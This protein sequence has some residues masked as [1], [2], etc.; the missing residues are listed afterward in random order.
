MK[1]LVVFPLFIFLFLSIFS[2]SAHAVIVMNVTSLGDTFVDMAHP[3]YGDGTNQ[4]LTV[5]PSSTQNIFSYFLYN[6]SQIPSNVTISS[7]Q[8]CV[9]KL[10]GTINGRQILAYNTSPMNT[11][12]TTYWNEGNLKLTNCTGAGC[13]LDRN[14]TWSTHPAN[15]TLL[16]NIT[17][18]TT[19]GWKC[20]NVTKAMISS[21][22]QSKPLSIM[23]MDGHTNETTGNNNNFYSKEG[24]TPPYLTVTFTGSNGCGTTIIGSY[25]DLSDPSHRGL[26]TTPDY[27]CTHDL[28]TVCPSNS[29]C[30]QITPQINITTAP[31]QNGVDCTA[32]LFVYAGSLLLPTINCGVS[33][34]F[35]PGCFWTNCPNDPECQC[36]P[37]NIIPACYAN[38]SLIQETISSTPASLGVYQA[39][40]YDPNTKTYIIAVDENGTNTTIT[41]ITLRFFPNATSYN[42]TNETAGACYA[43]TSTVCYNAVCSPVACTAAG[44]TTITSVSWFGMVAL[45]WGSIFGMGDVA[46]IDADIASMSIVFALLIAA[47][48]AYFLKKSPQIFGFGFV[49][50]LMVFTI[51]SGVNVYLLF[52]TILLTVMVVGTITGAFKKWIGG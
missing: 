12:G 22:S 27:T 50:M 21:Y 39:G 29:V 16:D 30:S 35:G 36:R 34:G 2:V 6:T 25:C 48:F 3:L 46:Y 10:D 7:A 14:L 44:N 11:T 13:N 20:F 51:M 15:D 8:L 31:I 23:L 45:A 49:G 17:T 28:Y 52:I 33:A 24:G 42:Y 4:I 1:K 26:I 40:C 47:M 41:N 19:A 18:S 37:N 43:N 5:M 38:N 32:C 9:Y